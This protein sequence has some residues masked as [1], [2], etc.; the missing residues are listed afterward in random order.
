MIETVTYVAVLSY[1]LSYH[2]V[3]TFWLIYG[4]KIDIIGIY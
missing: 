3:F 2:P 4:K 1:H